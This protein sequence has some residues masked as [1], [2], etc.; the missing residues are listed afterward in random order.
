MYMEN[1]TW[2]QSQIDIIKIELSLFLWVFGYCLNFYI[3]LFTF[4]I[5][6]YT[7]RIIHGRVLVA[8]LNL[9]MNEN[10]YVDHHIQD[11]SPD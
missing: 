2:N 9:S 7:R 1:K 3:I 5:L 8:A 4:A 10:L 6:F 11:I